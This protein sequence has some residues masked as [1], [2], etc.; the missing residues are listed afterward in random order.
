MS[1][2]GAVFAWPPGDPGQL[3]ELAGHLALVASRVDQ[4]VVA[5]QGGHGWSLARSWTGPAF[6]AARAEAAVVAARSTDLAGGLASVVAA[7][8][9]YA[10]DLQ[11]ARQRVNALEQEWEH[12]KHRFDRV[13][14]EA[15]S[16]VG[17]PVHA[18][19]A[20][21]L[22]RQ[23]AEREWV[24]LQ[25][26]LRGRHTAVLA[27]LTAAA[28]RAAATVW[29]V[30]DELPGQSADEVRR[31]LLATLPL[32]DGALR[33]TQAREL[34]AALV[35]AARRPV[36]D[37]G[38]PEAALI[39]GLGEQ[40][41]DPI[42]AQALLTG[43]P[44]EI[45]MT[46]IARLRGH[47][48]SVPGEGAAWEAQFDP[49]LAVLGT[50]FVVMSSQG[51]WEQL[52]DAS[53][54]R[55]ASWQR[56]WLTELVRIG[57]QVV[58]DEREDPPFRGFTAVGV[59]LDHAGRAAA[60]VRPGV[61]FANTVGLAMVDLD[62]VR[63]DFHPRVR[64]PAVPRAAAEG[65]DAIDALLR[66]VRGAP[67]TASAL[68][69]GRLGNG[70]TVAQYLAGDRPIRGAGGPPPDFT[71]ALAAV[72]AET[73]TGADM[74]SVRIAGAALDGFGVAAEAVRGAETAE[75]ALAIASQLH[76]LRFVMAD[77]LSHHP[78]AI[79]ATINDPADAR[80]WPAGT[81]PGHPWAVLGDD[82]WT[83]RVLNRSR[84]AAI[85]GELGTDRLVPGRA[86][87]GP[88]TAPALARLLNAV[89]AAE[90]AEVAS[91][92]ASGDAETR[93]AA[94]VRLG[95][96]TGF[97]VEAARQAVLGIQS[98]ADDD[99]A[100]R[101]AT[102]DSIA[103]AITLPTVV[104]TSLPTAVAGVVLDM[105]RKAVTWIGYGDTTVNNA[106]RAAADTAA[107]R[108]RIEAEMRRA[109]WDLVS[110]A[111]AWPTVDDPASWVRAHPGVSFCGPDGRPL[112]LEEMT[113]QQRERF[114]AWSSGVPAYTTVP[115]EI[116]AQIEEGARA[117]RTSMPAR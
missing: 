98:A 110:A 107:A 20:H 117:V 37:W 54:A 21:T 43:L 61:P 97:V 19:T 89:V 68:L 88:P 2:R 106:A 59:L 15:E 70:Q 64:V 77:L 6:E 82:G 79:W 34:I 103:S 57:P 33:A 111:G 12:G 22:A 104:R 105:V 74:R 91:G 25:A 26:Q 46:Y 29:G 48:A 60:A 95:Q 76:E 114:V 75:A 55:L 42:V 30:L 112:P 78:D 44:P 116:I 16:G 18:A 28:E 108:A 84:L 31:G 23:A 66:S 90:A 72:L 4:T 100:A 69:L 87:D 83:V 51:P 27:A 94:L 71:E 92:L 47:L 14:H 65:L 102:V 80:A 115:A 86:A 17:D 45:L 9:G 81:T 50:A 73:A 39:A 49:A 10:A 7:L 41:R 3:S 85:I 38:A 52:D 101:R 58:G 56:S 40:V 36:Q 32:T 67:E 96:V 63:D 1:T 113:P 93:A 109:G 24:G 53:A 13:R 99:A 62:R 8:Q 11:C 35:A 5:Q